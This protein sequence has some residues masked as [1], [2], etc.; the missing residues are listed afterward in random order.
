MLFQLHEVAASI[1]VRLDHLKST[2]KSI[3]SEPPQERLH[4]ELSMAADRAAE[5]SHVNALESLPARPRTH[6]GEAKRNPPLRS[7]RS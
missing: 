4:T 7:L 1:L 3:A 2:L 5:T 6:E